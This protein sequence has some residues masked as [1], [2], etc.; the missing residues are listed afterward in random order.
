M[1]KLKNE[2]FITINREIGVDF[3]DCKIV[4]KYFSG[5]FGDHEYVYIMDCTTNYKIIE[6]EIS[7][8]NECPMNES[9]ILELYGANKKPYSSHKLSGKYHIPFIDNCFFELYPNNLSDSEYDVFPH[10]YILALY[11]KNKHTFYY[12]DRYT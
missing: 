6:K 5:G 7:N 4:K 2:I 1:F 12:I 10:D 9:L 3:S 8:W 11:D